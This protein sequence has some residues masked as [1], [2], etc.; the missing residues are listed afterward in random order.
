MVKQSA[1][2][3]Q[4][5][6]RKGG[7]RYAIAATVLALGACAWLIAAAIRGDAGAE[8]VP[9]TVNGQDIPAAEFKMAL[10][11][12]R[13]LVA[14]KYMQAYGAEYGAAFWTT[15]YEGGTPLAELASAARK[16]LIRSAVAQS[17]AQRA[18]V[19]PAAGYAAFLEGMAAENDRRAKASA[20]GEVV[21]G[22]LS[23]EAQS[24]YSYYMS[25]LEN[26]TVEAMRK[27]GEI[28]VD[29]AKL[30]RQYEADKRDK[31]T[32]AGDRSLMWA[33]AAYGEGT[34]YGRRDDALAALTALREA[35]AGG[36]DFAKAAQ[37]LGIE[38]SAATLTASSRR[39]AALE[40]PLALQQAETLSPGGLTDIFEENGA[41][42]LIYC[43]SVGEAQIVPYEEAKE[44]IT[45]SL[46][47]EAYVE[48]VAREVGE[49]T[50][51]WNDKAAMK[52]AEAWTNGR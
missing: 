34:A 24:Y 22:P 36:M 13:A 33:T 14:D 52:I 6:K 44:A 15:R 50:V 30:K 35:A 5:R 37:G 32:Q 49:A 27:S 11:Q 23:F 47:T 2:G 48:R 16:Q 7:R 19:I 43:R 26:A 51:A 9:M 12:N 42:Q 46:A 20:N 1:I 39:S 4:P 3:M 8:P 45:R 41:L 25:N 28:V 18:G 31:Y 29:E 40:K 17:L 21:Y 38:A 10:D